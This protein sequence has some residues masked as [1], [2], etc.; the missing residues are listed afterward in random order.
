MPRAQLA[1]N[2]SNIDHAVEFY[3]KYFGSEPAKRRPGY[4]K[5]VIDNPPLKLVLIED[6]DLRG[7]GTAAALNHLGIEVKTTDEV[8]AAAARLSG[9]GLATVSEE[10]TSC[11][12]AIQD[13]VWVQ[14]P[15]GAPWEVY[16]VQ[17]EAPDS[18][19]IKGDA[20]DATPCCTP[21]ASSLHGATT[22]C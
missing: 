16:T 9:L 11:C 5:F 1:R 10:A 17:A 12:F 15:D 4:A 18:D 21:A 3:S 19:A 22:C 14:D 13:K 8:A 20:A 7:H 2:V 6:T